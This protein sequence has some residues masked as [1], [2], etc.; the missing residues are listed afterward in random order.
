MDHFEYE[1]Q[2][3]EAYMGWARRGGSVCHPETGGFDILEVLPSGHQIGIEAKIRLNL[4]VIQQALPTHHELMQR[5]GEYP[6]PD[7]R[8]I[9]VPHAADELV[10]MLGMVGLTVFVWCG[11]SGVSGHSFM[12]DTHGL[13]LFDWNPPKR[14]DVPKYA[15]NV[16]AGVPSPVRMTKWKIGALKIAAHL[17]LVGSIKRKEITAYGCS[18]TSFCQYGGWLEPVGEGR[19]VNRSMPDV[20][21]QHADVYPEV[22]REVRSA[23]GLPAG[24]T[25]KRGT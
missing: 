24:R 13:E 5:W 21:R 11:C 3:C 8:A 14:V 10:A 2:L 23:L 16:P 17:E 22:R 18:P 19:F 6:G 12:P 7:H 25:N 1:T 15:S 4:K 9:L 20:R